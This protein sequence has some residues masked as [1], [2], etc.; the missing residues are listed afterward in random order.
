M[1]VTCSGACTKRQN[2]YPEAVSA[3]EEAVTF[4]PL[5][6]LNGIYQTIGALQAAQQNFEGALA[7]YGKRVDT[8]PNDPGAHQALGDTYARLGRSDEAIAELA[9]TLILDPAQTAAYVSMGQVHLGDGRYAEALEASRR[10]LAREAEHKEA[11]YM[12][13]T[14][15][16]RLGRTEE[17]SKELQVFQ[18]LQAQDAAEKS[19]QFELGA[20]RRQAQVSAAAQDHQ[21]AIELLSKALLLDRDSSAA[22]LDLGLAL[23]KAGR[24][25][26]AIDELTRAA[27]PSADY[28]VYLHLADAYAAAGQ[29]EESQRARTT[30]EKMKQQSL[31]RDGASR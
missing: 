7:A 27:A 5:L 17:G 11:Q 18:R 28:D 30:Y 20:L 29:P 6:G 26:E 31:R 25:A 24:H 19:R 16:I 12:L 8:H 22:H 21:K 15:M 10:A 4:H 13:A 9:V 2:R 23:V 3:L 1:P 14:S